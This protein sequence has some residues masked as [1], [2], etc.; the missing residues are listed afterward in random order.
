M[1]WMSRFGGGF[2]ILLLAVAGCRKAPPAVV[3]PALPPVPADRLHFQEG[4]KS[5][6]EFTP[7]GYKR[8]I[9]RFGQASALAPETC[10]YRLHAA[11][12]HL[13]LALEQKLNREEFREAWE[14]GADPGC[15]PGSAFA[16]R[17]EA[18][19][20]LDE[21]GIVRDRTVLAKINQAIEID[22]DDVFSRYVLWKMKPDP[23]ID[24]A[25]LALIQ[26]ELGNYRLIRGDYLRGQRAFER[27]LE[28]S[29]RHF[30]SLIG[31]AQ[32]Q[33]AIDEDAAV[34]PLY[35]RAVE[36]AP[37]FL[38][39]RILLGDYYSALEENELAREQYLAA[40]GLNAGFE[41]ANLRLGLSYLQSSELDDAQNAFLRAIEI[42]PSSYEAFYYLGNIALLRGDLEQARGRY[43]ESLKFVLNFPDAT[44]ALGAVFFRQGKIDAALQQFEKVLRL[45]RSHADAYFSRAAIRAQRNEPENAIAD[46][47]RAIDLYESQRES[48]TKAI[49]EY[50]DRGLARKAEAERTK[51][52][53]IE[54]NLERA[55]QLKMKVAAGGLTP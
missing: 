33:S 45:N 44:Y 16:L 17:L 4:L 41:I 38:E 54:G 10:E 12:A 14:K 42:N 3:A 9:E 2:L 25:E 15:A 43:E 24:E 53:R 19:R 8:A 48:M 1:M 30:K 49:E 23:V 29:P 47:E 27:A 28:L 26:Y 7:E 21:F 46:Y 55:R 20:L 31:L 50:E 32:A 35:K 51:R 36:L 6:H 5:F 40:L 11:Q 37:G 22:P 52:Q 13:F 18:F 34:E 39:G